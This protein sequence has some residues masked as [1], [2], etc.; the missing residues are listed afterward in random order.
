MSNKLLMFVEGNITAGKGPFIS[1]LIRALSVRSRCPVHVHLRTVGEGLFGADVNITDLFHLDPGRWAAEFLMFNL[2]E[3]LR[4]MKERCRETHNSII[5]VERSI[6]AESEV[7]I[8]SLFECG[9]ISQLTHRVCMALV[10][11]ILDMFEELQRVTPTITYIYLRT[12]PTDLYECLVGHNIYDC[13]NFNLLQAIH[14]NYERFISEVSAD[15]TGSKYAVTIDMPYEQIMK[16]SAATVRVAL[17]QL[18]HIYPALQGEPGGGGSSRETRGSPVLCAT[19]MSQ[20]P[21]LSLE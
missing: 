16:P 3:K 18:Q 8:K 15:P 12:D 7:F 21:Q 2:G 14:R 20:P 5:I 6:A 9:M 19:D 17:K 13:L 11:Q 4:F 1:G 10:A